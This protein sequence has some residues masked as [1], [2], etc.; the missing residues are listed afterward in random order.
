MNINST[1]KGDYIPLFHFFGTKIQNIGT[2]KQQNEA[3]CT[4]SKGVSSYN[5]KV[6]FLSGLVF[7][8]SP[9]GSPHS[10]DIGQAPCGGGVP[11]VRAIWHPHNSVIFK[12]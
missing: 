9:L 10:A 4:R 11:K 8:E 1:D 7:S 6:I 5:A 2:T 12:V 3:N